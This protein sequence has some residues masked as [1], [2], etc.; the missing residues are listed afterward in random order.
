MKTD[1]LPAEIAQWYASRGMRPQN[2]RSHE[3]S[4]FFA[5]VDGDRHIWRSAS[6]PEWNEWPW[7][8]VCIRMSYVPFRL[9]VL[10]SQSSGDLAPSPWRVVGTRDPQT[11]RVTVE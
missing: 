7:G 2:V 4:V 10:V 8:C 3:Q 1:T 5:D 11:G 9:W 6:L